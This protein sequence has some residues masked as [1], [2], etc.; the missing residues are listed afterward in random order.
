M[1]NL[2]MF[3]HDYYAKRLTWSNETFLIFDVQGQ[4]FKTNFTTTNNVFP[5][6]DMKKINIFIIVHLKECS[7]GWILGL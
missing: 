7:C 1:H 2:N 4:N 3:F 6:L 5:Y